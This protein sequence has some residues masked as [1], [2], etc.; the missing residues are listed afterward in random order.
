MRARSAKIR[1]SARASERETAADNGGDAVA[2]TSGGAVACATGARA[3]EHA[4]SSAANRPA[5]A[6]GAGRELF[7]FCLQFAV[8]VAQRIDIGP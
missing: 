7:D 6:L 5:A 4:Q 3:P 1:S 8:F 2:P